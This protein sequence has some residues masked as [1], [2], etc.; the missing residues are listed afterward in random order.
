MAFF[1]PSKRSTARKS[2]AGLTHAAADRPKAETT[3]PRQRRHPNETPGDNMRRPSPSNTNAAHTGGNGA[4]GSRQ[5]RNTPKESPRPSRRFFYHKTPSAKPPR[6]R[7]VSAPGKPAANARTET[8]GDAPRGVFAPCKE[9]PRQIDGRQKSA[10]LNKPPDRTRQPP[11]INVTRSDGEQA[12]TARKRRKSASGVFDG[13]P[14]L[15][16]ERTRHGAFFG[17]IRRQEI[18]RPHET[19]G[20]NSCTTATAPRTHAGRLAQPSPA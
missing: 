3:L 12:Q 18:V 11:T 15:E 16:A 9:K 13:Q 4:T 20:G 6:K 19:S 14:H 10:R 2:D 5:E 17:A 7:R 1:I 8:H